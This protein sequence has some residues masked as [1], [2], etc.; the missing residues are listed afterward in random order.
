MNLSNIFDERFCKRAS[1][2]LL[3]GGTAMIGVMVYRAIKATNDTSEEDR[4]KEKEVVKS[5]KAAPVSEVIEVAKDIV[6]GKKPI[7]TT[8]E[9]GEKVF[10]GR[11]IL[12]KHIPAMKAAVAAATMIFSSHRLLRIALAMGEAKLRA[13]AAKRAA[14]ELNLGHVYRRLVDIENILVDQFHIHSRDSGEYH[15]GASTGFGTAACL[16]EA[17]TTTMRGWRMRHE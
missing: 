13:E 5:I 17:V 11:K 4:R 15:S 12:K 10:W 7:L 3:I 14:S 6:T 2:V 16:M 1:T 9:H 8:S